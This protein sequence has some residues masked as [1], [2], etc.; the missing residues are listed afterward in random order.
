MQEFL[1][2]EVEKPNPAS[3]LN[4]SL[5]DLSQFGIEDVDDNLIS[6]ALANH[7]EDPTNRRHGFPT[8]LQNHDYRQENMNL[9]RSWGFLVKLT[10][11]RAAL[12][13][14]CHST[15]ASLL[16]RQEDSCNSH[17]FRD[18]LASQKPRWHPPSA[19]NSYT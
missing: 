9:D 8:P 14:C 17:H 6:S 19:Y 15:R 1:L 16:L 18:Q 3:K 12:P 13:R 11:L 4:E 7:V 10:Q 5:P 2:L